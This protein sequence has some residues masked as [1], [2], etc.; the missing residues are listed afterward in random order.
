MS[1]TI[2]QPDLVDATQFAVKRVSKDSS[3]PILGGMLLE[4]YHGGAFAVTGFDRDVSHS[5]EIPRTDIDESE[6]TA[7]VSGRKL[8]ELVK[9]F[10]RKPVNLEQRDST[11]VLTCGSVRCTLPLMT[12]EDY[13]SLP[14]TADPIGTINALVLRE[15]VERVVGAADTKGENGKPEQTGIH[16]VFT[17]TTLDMTATNGYR[18]AMTRA[19]WNANGVDSGSPLALVPWSV[20][21]DFVHTLD[22]DAP[23]TIGLTDSVIS[24]TGQNRTVVARMLNAG[25]Y[26]KFKALP[27]KAGEPT[28]VDTAE[29]GAALKRAVLALEPKEAVSLAFDGDTVAV[30]GG[31]DVGGR[32]AVSSGV[33]CSHFDTDEDGKRIPKPPL[34]ITINPEYLGLALDACRSATAEL[35]LVDDPRRPVLVTADR[36][37]GFG[38]VIMPIR[39]R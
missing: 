20:L 18:V 16:C 30:H 38:W 10:P 3:D 33:A 37:D 26:P 29:L 13:P 23:V 15:H 8:A 22:A 6:G 39:K 7:V 21:G 34:T 5:M 32:T 2:E 31:M 1:C 27:P 28:T 36:V 19:P 9:T 17:A 24:L 12:A 14:S 11:L 25:G 35:T 4:A